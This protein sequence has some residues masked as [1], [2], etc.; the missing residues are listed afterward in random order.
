MPKEQI[1]KL[2][3]AYLKN[4][5]MVNSSFNDPER[6]DRVAT[7]LGFENN[8]QTINAETSTSERKNP[9]NN[10]NKGPKNK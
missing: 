5:K 8:K 7:R 1:T 6:R 2:S 10:D 3:N 4:A 9:T